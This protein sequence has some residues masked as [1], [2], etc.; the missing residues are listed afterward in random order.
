MICT[1]AQ[2]LW[3]NKIF[4]EIKKRGNRLIL[5]LRFLF[6]PNQFSFRYL[7]LIKQF[8]IIYS[9]SFIAHFFYAIQKKYSRN[10]R[11]YAARSH[12]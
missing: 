2:F 9:S 6:N 3:L 4:S 1:P 11:S 12:Q 5:V 7:H 8:E 10:H